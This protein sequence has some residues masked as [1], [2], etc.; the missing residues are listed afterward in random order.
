MEICLSN[1]KR[2]EGAKA[3][4]EMHVSS[5]NQDAIE[6]IVDNVKATIKD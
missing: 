3:V 2:Y 5:S 4:L 6:Q 1:P